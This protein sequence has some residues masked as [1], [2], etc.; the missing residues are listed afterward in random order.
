MSGIAIRRQRAAVTMYGIHQAPTHRGSLE[1]IP[2]LH[3]QTF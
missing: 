1:S 2:I 3:Q